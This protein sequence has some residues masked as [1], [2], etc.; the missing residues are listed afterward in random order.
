[1][2]AIIVNSAMINTASVSGVPIGTLWVNASL[3]KCSGLAQLPHSS[4]TFQFIFSILLP[5]QFT[6]PHSGQCVVTGFLD[7]IHSDFGKIKNFKVV[8]ICVSMV[9]NGVEHL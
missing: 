4:S 8:L 1:M 5:H 6:L 9:A 2:L 7:D 3:G